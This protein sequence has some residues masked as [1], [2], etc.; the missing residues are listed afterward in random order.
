MPRNHVF[1]HR[2]QKMKYMRLCY[3]MLM[4]QNN[5]CRAEQT[6]I[7]A[8]CHNGGYT[9]GQREEH[10]KRRVCAC[11]PNS[12]GMLLLRADRPQTW[13]GTGVL[14]HG[15]PH[16]RFH[17]L[18]SSRS[19]G[20]SH[21]PPRALAWAQPRCSAPTWCATAPLWRS[22]CTSLGRR[23]PQLWTG[24]RRTRLTAQY[25]SW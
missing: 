10:R 13:C 21:S 22:A 4:P 16:S 5:S 11:H 23:L 17:A 18:K 20:P 8:V 2:K 24:C 7:W 14:Q 9:T 12:G 3:A 19:P 1:L 25:C 15:G 6:P